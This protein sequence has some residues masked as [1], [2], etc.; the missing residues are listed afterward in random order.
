MLAER[1]RGSPMNAFRLFL[2]AALAGGSLTSCKPA[3]TVSM[4]TH[5]DAR[6]SLFPHEK[7]GALDCVDCHAAIPKATKLGEAQLPGLAKCEEC[8]PDIRKPTDEATRN[9]AA[10]AASLRARAPREYQISFNHA[11]HLTYVKTKEPN[12]ACKTCHKDEQLP[13]VGA[14]RSTA[15]QMQAC[16]ACHHHATEVAQA[17]CTPCHVSL[18]RFPLKPI[19]ALAGFSHQGNFVK[20]HGKLA[21]TSVETCAQCHDQTYCATCHATATVP[22]RPE[23]QFPENVEAN[24]IHRGDYVSRHQIEA[25]AD[26]SRCRKCHG[27]FFCDSCHTE[28]NISRRNTIAGGAP[29]NPHPPGWATPGSGDFHGT[30]ARQ[31]IITCAGC[32]DQQGAANLCVTC[33][34]SLGPGIPGVAGKS[35]HAPG[36]ASKHG[37]EE[38][39]KN[40]MC[41]ACH[42]NG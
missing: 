29:R 37:R 22:F 32:H 23:I 17:K 24:F 5:E 38:I 33:H 20:E 40:G 9:A 26:G 42:T 27:S 34:R 8:H 28:Q 21:R 15:P 35:P 13:E 4:E 7:H 14:P 36:F 30:A 39:R 11:D 10:A 16:T 18:R 41:V 3:R 2:M 1:R 31:N 19:E 12:D 6:T 25:A